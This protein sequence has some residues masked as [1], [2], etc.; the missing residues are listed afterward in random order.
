M[1]RTFLP[2]RPVAW[3]A[4]L[5]GSALVPPCAG[6]AED[7]RAAVALP[8][9][10]V[11]E[12]AKGPPW[13]YGEAMGFEVLS[14]CGDATTRRVVDAHFQLHSLLGEILPPA[15]R[16]AFSVRPALVLYD[17]ELQP[18]A[19]QEVIR[20]ML[21]TQ[22]ATAD[23]DLLAMAGGGFRGR[24]AVPEA[25][26]ARR[27][28]FS[29]N[30]RLW[31]RDSMTVFM[32]VRR[33]DFDG[34]RLA[35]THDYISFMVK[36]RVPTLPPWFGV[37]FLAFYRQVK[38]DGGR[39]EVDPL[40]WISRVQ[41][42]ALKA[43]PKTAVPVPPLGDFLALRMSPVPAPHAVEPMKVWAAQA[44]LFVRWGLD[45]EK[46][47][48]RP[49]FWRFVERCAVESP[50]EAL[51]R[52]C[53]GFDFA[54]AQT[55]LAA[56]LATAVRRGPRF[57]PARRPKLPAWELRNASDV[58]IARI[59]GDMERLEVPYVKNLSAELAPKYLEQ[60]RRTLRRAYD[61]DAREPG[62][63]A[64]MGLCEVD[65]GNDAGAHELLESA[66]RL[67][68]LRPRANYELGRLRLAAARAAAGAP[69]GRLSVNQT[70][71]VLQPLFAAR[72]GEP[73]LPEVYEAIADTWAAT[74]ATPTRGHLAVLDE[75]VRLFPRRLPLVF[76]AA[77]LN[78]KHGYG[79][80]AATY[81]D[82]ADRLATPSGEERERVAALRRALGP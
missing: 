18:A 27:Y 55:Q 76:R 67:G 33:D 56:Y 12:L 63:L 40:E 5:A 10:I 20:Q 28:S 14:R 24:G 65:G 53:F 43:D 81:A 80:V 69:D 23:T 49:A 54:A 15:L 57:E 77:E 41:T 16:V 78:L 42:E 39:L 21:K 62:L 58:E 7:A 71:E 35:L 64:V 26:P 38:F 50:S 46:Q 32:I 51:F 72:Q 19:S 9:F 1:F 30:L 52:E 73:P 3:A 79:E 59:K 13:R 70:A 48:L 47:T 60:A 2:S 74:S 82:I 25:T 11:E 31:D 29:P 4:L 8:P 6:A 75:G 17:E 61:R 45:A 36:S 37:G 68:P 34:D 66:A 44:E 22:P